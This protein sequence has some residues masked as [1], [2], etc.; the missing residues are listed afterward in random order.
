MDDILDAIKSLAAKVDKLE[1]K[2]ETKNE[3]N[4][5]TQC[6]KDI[7][8]TLDDLRQMTPLTQH[9]YAILEDVTV[10][11]LPLSGKRN[12]KTSAKRAIIRS[13]HWPHQFVHRPGVSDILCT[14]P[15]L[16]RGIRCVVCTQP[17][18]KTSKRVNETCPIR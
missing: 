4:L 2:V 14:Y 12:P 9:A 8:I 17:R 7:D 11:S 10:T 3:E 1:K 16:F 13:I 6:T 15:A 18:W 5:P